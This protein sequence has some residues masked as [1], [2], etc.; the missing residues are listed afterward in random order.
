MSQ[1][2]KTARNILVTGGSSGIGAAIRDALT[3]AGY[4]VYVFSR[5]PPALW[6]DPPKGQTEWIPGDLADAEQGLSSLRSALSAPSFA[7]DGLFHCA[8]DY[9][10]G[11]RH[12]FTEISS[13]EWDAVFRVNV[14]GTFGLLQL[15]VPI[16]LQR[17]RGLI[18]NLSSDAAMIA[19]PGRCAYSSSKAA[20]HLMFATLALELQDFGISVV[21]LLPSRPVDTPGIRRR[22]PERFD[23]NGYLTP[24]HFTEPVLRLAK[25]LG[26]GLAGASIVVE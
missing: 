8:V 15:V 1:S 11:S 21:Q 13:S 9:G 19:K 17:R 4:N 10:V 6:D 3:G 7:L 25:N 14:N 2:S 26:S 20:S 23:Y 24:A 5:R 12:S 16:M 22:R 18:V